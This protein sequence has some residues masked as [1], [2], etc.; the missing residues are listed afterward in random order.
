MRP[1][2]LASLI[3]VLANCAN[4]PENTQDTAR[5]IDL[6]LS[7]GQKRQAF[8][9]NF[10]N[11][12][13]ELVYLRGKFLANRETLGMTGSI[14]PCK[15]LRDLNEIIP[16]DGR[17]PSPE[18]EKRFV[19]IINSG[20]L[21]WQVSYKL[22][23]TAHGEYIPRYP[24]RLFNDHAPIAPISPS[25]LAGQCLIYFAEITH[26]IEITATTRVSSVDILNIYKGK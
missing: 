19:Q 13:G 5:M 21:G 9:E 25:E 23:S 8:Q 22:N 15:E 12:R 14:A 4:T 11:S 1:I 20:E 7:V 17:Y 3:A 2:F 24:Q 6:D 16:S 26:K 10:L 18:Q